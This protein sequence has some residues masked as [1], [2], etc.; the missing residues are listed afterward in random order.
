MFNVGW[1]IKIK[2]LK[3]KRPKYKNKKESL[4][5]SEN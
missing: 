1:A 2:L 4:L 5:Q 3:T